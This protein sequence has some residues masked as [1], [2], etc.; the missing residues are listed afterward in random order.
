MLIVLI[1]TL[2]FSGYSVTVMIDL[3]N[4]PEDWEVLVK[5]IG[6]LKRHCFAS[7]FEK[8]FDFQEKL[9]QSTEDCSKLQKKA[10]IQYR[11]QEIM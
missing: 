1:A 10:I 11:D 7:V 8:Y 6:L 9:S 5:K 4:I 2:T 3:E